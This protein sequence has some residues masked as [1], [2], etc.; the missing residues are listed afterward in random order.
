MSDNHRIREAISR[1]L[2]QPSLGVS[3]Q[4]LAVH[5]PRRIDGIPVIARIA[6][7][8]T[9]GVWH[10]YLPLEEEPYF[11]VIVLE[12]GGEEYVPAAAYIEASIRIYLSITS[13]TLAASE[14]TSRIG[15]SP[16]TVHDMGSPRRGGARTY[17]YHVWEY[18]PEPG[19]PGSFEERLALLLGHLE[20]VESQIAGLGNEC[21]CTI[22]VCGEHYVDS[23]GGWHIDRAMMA[24]MTRLGVELDYD[25]YVSGPEL[26]S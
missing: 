26:P 20:Q 10:V 18:Q 14:I 19:V 24:S 13:T 11:F 1:E 21:E 5:R 12:E 7:T 16:T 3:E 2:D 15:L 4:V 23:P 22:I 17:A 25:L 6:S 9:P 8:E